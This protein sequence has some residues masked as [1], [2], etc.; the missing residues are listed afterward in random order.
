MQL[1]V[2]RMFRISPPSLRCVSYLL[3]LIFRG[4]LS[5]SFLTRCF[6][7]AGANCTLLIVGAA[8]LGGSN[9]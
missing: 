6:V 4:N 1:T 3:F 8:C 9:G 5:L 2:F 7:T